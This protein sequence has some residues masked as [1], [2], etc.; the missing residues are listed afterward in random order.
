[1]VRASLAAPQIYICSIC[2]LC[3]YLHGLF[4][5]FYEG[6]ITRHWVPMEGCLTRHW[7]PTT[8]AGTGRHNKALRVE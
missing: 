6:W 3:I 8:V 4:I 1:M 7:V 2:L 5:M